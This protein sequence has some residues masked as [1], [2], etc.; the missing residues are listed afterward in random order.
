M[1][2]WNFGYV[3]EDNQLV[4]FFHS[5]KEG[6]KINAFK[7]NADICFEMDC[8]HKLIT[9]EEACRF[10]FSFRSIVGNGRVV[11]IDDPE[12]KKHA[13]SAL[14]KHQTGRDFAFDDRMADSVCVFKIIANEFTGKY[15]P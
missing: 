12:E 5:A 10:S 9:G 4:L 11:F 15:H 6:R 3:Y 14:M 2:L 13:L 8:D 7:E 1:I